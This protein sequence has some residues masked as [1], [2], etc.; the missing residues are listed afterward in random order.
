MSYYYKFL[1]SDLN[2]SNQVYNYA[3][4]TYDLTL[5]GATIVTGTSFDNTKTTSSLFLNNS[6]NTRTQYATSIT[7]FTHVL[8]NGF[9][10]S[11][12]FMCKNDANSYARIC[13]LLG[14]TSGTYDRTECFITYSSSYI[15]YG[16]AINNSFVENSFGYSAPLGST[17]NTWVHIAM[18][19]SQGSSTNN[20]SLYINGALQ[21]TLTNATYFNTS[22]R[23][24][25]IGTNVFGNPY[26][27]GY[28]N[29]YR[30]YNRALNYSEIQLLY[31]SLLIG[32][33][34]N[35][36][37]AL[38]A[39]SLNTYTDYLTVNT[40]N[41]WTHSGRMFIAN[42]TGGVF[43]F[44]S[45]IMP[46]FLIN[47]WT[48]GQSVGVLSQYVYLYATA[49]VL[50]FWAAVRP[51]AYDIIHQFSVV[52]GGTTYFTSSFT[53]TNTVW[54]QYFVNFT[55]STSDSYNVVFNFTTATFDSSIGITQIQFTQSFA[56]YNF[57]LPVVSGYLYT[58]TI[59]N[60][61]ITGYN[62]I[63]GSGN[64]FGFLTCPFTQFLIWQNT[65][66]YPIGTMTQSIYLYAGSYTISFWAAIRGGIYSTLQ[67]VSV[68]VG[69]T[70]YFTSALTTSSTNWRQ[71][72]VNFPILTNGTYTITFSFSVGASDSSIGI[73]NILIYKPIY[74]NNQLSTPALLTMR[75]LYAFKLLM[76]TYSGPIAK[77]RRVSDGTS[78]DFYADISGNIGTTSYGAGTTLASWLTST[79]G[80]VSTWYDQSGLGNNMIQSNT[81]YQPQIILN[82]DIGI[83]LYVNIIA[84]TN[85]SQLQ[86]INN[87]FTTSTVVDA[88]IVLHH[89]AITYVSSVTFSL[90]SPNAYSGTSRF[91]AHLP[92]TDGTY[93]FDAGD[94]NTGRVNSTS[95]IIPAGTKVCFSGYKKSSTTTKGFSV[96]DFTYYEAAGNPVAT[97]S[98]AGLNFSD[99][100]TNTNTYIYT[101][102][103]FSKS[104]YNTNDEVFLKSLLSFKIIPAQYAALYNI[105]TTK[106]P[107]GIYDANK[108]NS[109]TN[110]L[111]EARGYDRNVTST[112]TVTR[113]SGS[114]NGASSAIS[115][116]GGTTATTLTWPTGSIPTNFTI[117][118]VTR[119]TGGTSRRILNGSSNWLHGHWNGQRGVCHYDGWKTASTGVGTLQNW[120]VCC[121]NNGA[122]IPNNILIDSVASGTVTG[123]SSNQPLYINTGG[124]N[125]GETTDFQFSYLIIWNQILTDA[126]MLTT[127]TA[128][129]Y[130]LSSGI[131]LDVDNAYS[132][133][134]FTNYT[135][136]VTNGSYTIFSY[137]TVGTYTNA[138]TLSGSASVNLQIF[139][140]GGGGAGGSPRNGGGGGGAGGIVQSTINITSSD[141]ISLTVGSG[142]AFS[143][144]TNSA[145]DGGNTAATFATNTANN[146]T[147]YGGG[148]G[149]GFGGGGGSAG[150]NGGCGGGASYSAFSGGTGV[151]GQGFAGGSTGGSG[152][153]AGAGGGGT[154]TKGVDTSSNAGTNGGDGKQISLNMFTGSTYANYFW[155]GGGGGGG[156]YAA[157][158]NGGKGGG[159]GGTP[160]NGGAIGTGDTTGI[161]P[162]INSTLWPPSSANP[163]PNAGANTG[164]GGGGAGQDD[165]NSGWSVGNGGSG[166]ILIAVLTSSL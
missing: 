148:G 165:Q 114:G 132:P 88:H 59:S 11:G 20:F 3:T 71:Y 6:S 54:T 67:Q 161:N 86:T 55:I 129:L 29:E 46:Q 5:T 152:I 111:P 149:G 40:I 19:I 96:N 84:G 108:W 37:F 122:A 80:Y 109:S 101:F 160:G 50:S 94:A 74:L 43:G 4:K 131:P 102:A 144:T 156:T 138:I 93:Y 119:Y 123:G 97:V 105:Y 124:G 82:D 10:F 16:I 44:T 153:T 23:T 61:T 60:W 66:G 134:V 146:I 12:W 26:Y 127:S 137:K 32:E 76:N 83:C 72:F 164:G 90:D 63:I 47:Q 24:M 69:G 166:I 64:G 53:P 15:Y 135:D 100:G 51:S 143:T 142:G 107:W 139:T 140:I 103:L 65:S 77:I 125:Y 52:I 2:L 141:R 13:E 31:N 78:S 81:I 58:G 38:P 33:L 27:Y 34:N 117:C 57:A 17:N 36:N 120:L 35:Y 162:G 158:G 75:G 25:T 126:E 30:I 157:G 150:R 145:L 79:T 147:A 28:I 9:T 14:G 87:A 70:T 41:R 112:G 121:G 110:I 118:S 133:V 115:Y 91:G 113:G 18:V 116:I 42:G 49:Y 95:N 106:K 159:G 99:G 21:N 1:S 56:N 85:A 73:A 48:T 92:W 8:Q 39:Q 136:V 163:K 22:T 45:C 89:K 68:I 104:L 151:S 155:G 98:K 154:A 130:Y 128:L 7:P 62:S